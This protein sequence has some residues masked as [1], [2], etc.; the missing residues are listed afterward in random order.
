MWVKKKK[1]ERKERKL[2]VATHSI[3]SNDQELVSVVQP[4][5][6]GVRVSDDELLD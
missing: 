4:S 5:F 6:S 1:K 3:T 2:D